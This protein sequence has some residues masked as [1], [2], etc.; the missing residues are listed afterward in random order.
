MVPMK[1][2]TIWM[3]PFLL[4]SGCCVKPDPGPAQTDDPQVPLKLQMQSTPAAFVSNPSWDDSANG[5]FRSAT[6]SSPDS[7]GNAIAAASAD[8]DEDGITDLIT[9]F[10]NH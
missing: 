4:L 6:Y 3:L 9:G 10:E 8:F 1:Q 5:I 2:I 7:V